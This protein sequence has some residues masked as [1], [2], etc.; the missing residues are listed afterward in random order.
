LEEAFLDALLTLE[1]AFV[2]ERLTVDRVVFD[3]TVPDAIVAGGRLIS[4]METS[5]SDVIASLR[6]P[7]FWRPAMRLM[8]AMPTLATSPV[9][10]SGR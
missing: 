6:F 3:M 10:R 7:S 8:L 2:D 5:I 9:E 4:W 1:G